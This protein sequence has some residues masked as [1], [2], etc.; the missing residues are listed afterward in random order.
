MSV[1]PKTE[2][3]ERVSENFNIFWEEG[4]TA[5]EIKELNS[6]NQN[7]R[8]VTPKLIDPVKILQYKIIFIYLFF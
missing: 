8:T 7:L 3:V 2:K 4:L 1:I 6:L 5:E